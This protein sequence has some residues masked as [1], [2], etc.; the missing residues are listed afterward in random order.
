MLRG[1]HSFKLPTQVQFLYLTHFVGC[2]H[3]PWRLS[4]RES[5]HA[6]FL[7]GLGYDMSSHIA[8]IAQCAREGIGIGYGL[9]MIVKQSLCEQWL[10][11]MTV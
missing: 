6:E 11:W 7:G 10:L 3:T 2:I 4:H 1:Q 9:I 8:S 5:R